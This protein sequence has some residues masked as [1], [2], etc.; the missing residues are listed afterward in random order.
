[1]GNQQGSFAATRQVATYDG[2][3]VLI[4]E[5][6]VLGAGSFAKV[7]Q[8]TILQADLSYKEMIFSL[9]IFLLLL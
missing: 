4:N 5:N 2:R 8:V 3:I 7:V 6:C 9:A 1:M